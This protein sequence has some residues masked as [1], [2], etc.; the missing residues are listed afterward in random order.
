MKKLLE[1]FQNQ[2]RKPFENISRRAFFAVL[3]LA[4]IFFSLPGVSGCTSAGSQNEKEGA[5]PQGSV[6]SN[7]TS[8]TSA[9]STTSQE[10][11]DAVHLDGGGFTVDW[12]EE[13]ELTD[14]L[15]LPEEELPVAYRETAEYLF[16][17]YEDHVVIERYLGNATHVTIPSEYE[18]LPVTE[19][20]GEKICC[21][22]VSLDAFRGTAVEEVVIPESVTRIGEGA[23]RGCEHLTSLTIP[24]SVTW[25]GGAAFYGTPWYDSLN[26]EFVIVGDG[27]LIK[28]NG[29]DAD[30]VIPDGVKGI[31][32]AFDDNENLT[33]VTIPES[34]TQILWDA[35]SGCA[36]L[37]EVYIPES[38][39]LI[40]D[41]AF[42][43]CKALAKVSGGAGITQIG[44]YA[45]S[46]NDA[47]S[48]FTFG[49]RVE[50][51]GYCAFFQC[52]AL[53]EV[54]FPDSLRIIGDQAFQNCSALATVKNGKNVIAVGYW[55]FDDTP[56]LEAQTDY[57]VVVGKNVLIEYNGKDKDLVLPDT[58]TYL[59]GAFSA[60]EELDELTSIVIPESV[61]GIAA[62]ALDSQM[63][64]ASITIEG[65]RVT[66]GDNS[67]ACDHLTQVNLPENLTVLPAYL[68]T[69]ADIT[70]IQIPDTVVLI[71]ENAF[72]SCAYLT[73]VTIPEACVM[74]DEYAFANCESLGEV[75]ILNEETY[76]AEGIFE[77][78]PEELVIHGYA[79][80]TAEEYAAE[81]G[82]EFEGI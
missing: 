53:T 5:V 41:N 48:D 63:Y 4:C 8:G 25:I 24:E 76:L 77:G 9:T 27:L 39:S 73:E 46:Y 40:G 65:D 21:D 33:S 42:N 38:V 15:A 62:R 51:I 16:A 58:I 50:E 59:G 19:I 61:R 45:F 57:Y 3:I 78:C 60:M 32:G 80:S 37:T 81:Y 28:Y 10:E 68:L 69:R 36:A 64:L 22:G 49:E 12:H 18:G 55:A 66:C 26:D 29:T 79:G 75:W 71:G 43:G 52:T 1:T 20:G 70:E 82:I 23:F 11:I 72:D 14:D 6:D 17:I 2:P 56:W 35:F 54:D 34:V 44:A 74:V 13:V 30:V 7:G 47:L 67:L 31:Y